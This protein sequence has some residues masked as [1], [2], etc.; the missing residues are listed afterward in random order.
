MNF[1]NKLIPGLLI[2]RY[3]RFFVDVRVNNQILTVHCPN[4]GSMH[5]LLDQGNKVWI[6]KSNNPKRKLKYTLEIIEVK[7]TKVGINTHSTNKIVHDALQNNLIKGFNN[8]MDIKPETK[9]GANT[10]FD[11][12]VSSKKYQSFIE[13]KNVTLSRKRNLAEFPDA[14]TSRGLKHIGELIKASKKKFK[15]YILFVIQRNDC[16]SFSIAKDID[17]NY[18]NA[19]SKAV[20]NN[21]KILCYDCKFSPKGIK[22]NRQIKFILNE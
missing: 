13:V 6:S 22:L 17:P 2:K 7:K 19:L 15:V 20:K 11:F 16:N 5:G 21:L 12:L 1:D 3:K 8:N 4:T 9:F 18:A 10:R 14:E